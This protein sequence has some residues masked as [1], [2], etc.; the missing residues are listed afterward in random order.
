MKKIILIL[1]I[2]IIIISTGN[3]FSLIT[4][5]YSKPTLIGDWVPDTCSGE[6]AYNISVEFGSQRFLVVAPDI[7]FVTLGPDLELQKCLEK[8]YGY[9]PVDIKD[10]KATMWYFGGG[11]KVRI[12]S[13]TK[14][15]PYLQF[16]YF[17]Y[18]KGVKS[19]WVSIPLF[20]NLETIFYKHGPGISAGL[21][22]YPD[23]IISVVAGIRYF[24]GFGSSTSEIEE[25][26]LNRKP[27]DTQFL[28]FFGGFNLL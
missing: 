12:L 22:L 7:G 18:R 26:F 5:G 15:T 20:T 14:F 3:I 25:N 10:I 8:H 9:L 17:I 4:L 13:N 16:S 19:G 27:R 2:T 11:M 21:E 28:I 6:H 24:Y 23:N 1:T